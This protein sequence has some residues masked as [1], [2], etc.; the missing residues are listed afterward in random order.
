MSKKIL[1][2]A[3]L[4]LV[5]FIA[6]YYQ[7]NLFLSPIPI[8]ITYFLIVLFIDSLLVGC[9]IIVFDYTFKKSQD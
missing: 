2:I 8:P 4:L 6:F 3:L 9:A 1:M 7:Y 5:T